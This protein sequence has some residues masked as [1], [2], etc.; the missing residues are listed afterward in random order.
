MLLKPKEVKDERSQRR[1]L[2]CVK[3]VFL[4][5]ELFCSLKPSHSA[6]IHPFAQTFQMHISTHPSPPQRSVDAQGQLSDQLL[7]LFTAKFFP[8]IG[9]DLSIVG[10]GVEGVI[11]QITEPESD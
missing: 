6:T 8:T 9:R 7:N 3:V 5:A 11:E 2:H 10:E 4:L 1:H